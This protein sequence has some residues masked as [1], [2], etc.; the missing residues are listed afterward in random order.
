MTEVLQ[1]PVCDFK[2]NYPLPNECP[3]CGKRNLN[4]DLSLIPSMHDL[5][6]YI[7]EIYLRIIKKSRL[8]F[9]AKKQYYSLLDE[10]NIIRNE[11]TDIKESSLGNLLNILFGITGSKNENLIEEINKKELEINQQEKIY[12]K[13]E[14]ILCEKDI[15]SE[16]EIKD[17]IIVSKDFKYKFN[18]ITDAINSAKNGTRIKVMPGKYKEDVVIDK[19]IEIVGEGNVNQVV[20]ENKLKNSL[21]IKNSNFKISGLTLKYQ[22][23]IIYF[24]AY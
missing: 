21:L 24:L 15:Y 12:L 10:I 3:N 1:C 17:E 2:L 11:I 9:K 8:F 6:S 14:N 13:N 23:K 22:H 4:H 7:E 18:T 16:K 5:N 19:D 20:I